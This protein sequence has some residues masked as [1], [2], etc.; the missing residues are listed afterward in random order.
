MYWI[1][2]TPTH[3]LKRLPSSVS[4]VHV[5]VYAYVYAVQCL[6]IEFFFFFF[7]KLNSFVFL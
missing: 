3:L 1:P 4:T 6:K 5:H 7:T 2:T